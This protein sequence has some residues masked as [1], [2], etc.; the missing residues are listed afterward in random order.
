[1][2]YGYAL[3]AGN[4]AGIYVELSWLLFSFMNANQLKINP[5]NPQY[6]VKT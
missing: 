4:Y 3:V 6:Q 5:G 1:M 2:L